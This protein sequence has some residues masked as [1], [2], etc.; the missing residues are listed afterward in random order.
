[1][2]DDLVAS[3]G[4]LSFIC[5]KTCV[6]VQIRVSRF[7]FKEFISGIRVWNIILN[8]AFETTTNTLPYNFMNKIKQ[9]EIHG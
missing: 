3:Y 6:L 5:V 4:S 2:V 1:M 7:T 8:C 9:I